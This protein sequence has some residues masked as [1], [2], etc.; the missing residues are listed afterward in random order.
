VTDNPW[1]FW[2]GRTDILRSQALSPLES[3]V[4]RGIDGA[5]IARL[6]AKDPI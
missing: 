4:E 5:A 3:P 6:I 2:N 1:F